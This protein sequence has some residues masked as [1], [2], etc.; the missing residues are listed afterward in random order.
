MAK[1]PAAQR[2]KVKQKQRKVEARKKEA[3][4]KAGVDAKFSGAPKSGKRQ[5]PKAVHLDPNGE[6]LLQV[7]DPL[8]E[9]TKYMKLLK[10]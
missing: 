4:E 3:E 2:K 6:N 9:A 7:E 5:S 8:A 10:I 1:K